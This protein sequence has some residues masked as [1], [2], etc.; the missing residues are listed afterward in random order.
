MSKTIERRK[1]SPNEIAA[2]WGVA[3]RTVIQW[4]QNGDLRAI[5]GSVRRGGRPRYLIAE[6]DLLDFEQARRIGPPAPKLARRNL[7]SVPELLDE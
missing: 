3:T 7:P 2:M 5:D 6:D 4:I 1:Y